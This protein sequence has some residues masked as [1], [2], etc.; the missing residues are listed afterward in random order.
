M[1]KKKVIS[2]DRA[3]KGHASKHAKAKSKLKGHET[4]LAASLLAAD[5]TNEKLLFQAMYM[6]LE[7]LVS[8][9]IDMRQHTHEEASTSLGATYVVAIGGLLILAL[10][11]D[12]V[13]RREITR[14]IQ[15][16]NAVPRT[17]DL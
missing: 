11:G 10:D 8:S 4:V 12:A 6:N 17:D 2:I 9:A 15:Q 16:L 5:G 1:S 14:F 13:A 7:A 3:K